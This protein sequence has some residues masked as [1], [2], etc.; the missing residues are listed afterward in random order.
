MEFSMNSP[1][2]IRGSVLH[3]VTQFLSYRSQSIMVDYDW[4]KLVKVG[5]GVP[6]VN[7][8][9]LLLF[10]IYTLEQFVILE[11]KL[12]GYADDSILMAVVPSPG[13]TVTLAKFLKHDL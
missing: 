6:Q 7:V 12:I 8:L 11:N 10:L 3:T 9:G 1:V 2:V 13:I 4:S 5:S